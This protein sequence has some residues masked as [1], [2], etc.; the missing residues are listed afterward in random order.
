MVPCW[1]ASCS[2][3]SM[4][5]SPVSQCGV[6]FHVGQPCVLGWVWV[7]CWSALCPGV[8]LGSMPINL[9][10]WCRVGF[11]IGQPCVLGQGVFHIGQSCV[12]GWVWVPCRSTL[13][14][15]VGLG[16]M[17]VNPVS[18]CGVS[19]HVGQPCV[20]G[21]EWVPYWSAL[22]P[23]VE[24]GSALVSLCSLSLDFLVSLGIGMVHTCIRFFELF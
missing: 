13:C 18:W 11:H 24:L 15:G 23:G 10:S 19:L 5:V 16:S 21:W 6:G 14:S 2:W 1:H 12:L 8:G 20:L 17:S 3:G 9:V 7:P 22:G 4:L